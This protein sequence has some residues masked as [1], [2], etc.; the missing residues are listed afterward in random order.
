MPDRYDAIVVGVGGM[1]SAATYHLARRGCAVL[2]LE[3]FDVPHARGS[4]HG[5]TRMIRK[6][7][8]E[9]P[10]YVPL[11]DRAYDR[12]RDLEAEADE[13]LLFTEGSVAAGP[14]GS[15]DLAAARRTCLEHDLPFELLSSGEVADRYPAYDLP[16]DFRA[17][18][19][20]D[21]GFLAAE[22]CLLAHVR[23]AHAHGATIRAREPVMDWQ[24]TASG[25][26]VTTT[27]GT[28]AADRLVLT[29]GAW[30]G[31]LLE[32]LDPVT[33]VERQVL[34]WFQPR[35]PDR[36]AP[37]RFPVFTIDAEAGPLY[38]FP[39]FGVPGVKVGL[40]HHREEVVDPDADDWREPTP[41][42]ERLLRS[43]AER[44]VPAG[45]GPT[46]ALRTCLYTNSPDE[47]F[48]VDT[49]PAADEVVVAAG[50]SGHGYKFCSV[51]GE[52]LA[53]LV[54]TGTTAHPIGLFGLDRL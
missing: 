5:V 44:Y 36:F 28:Y 7:Y 38:G 35:D 21:G 17:L 14:A 30:T 37:E 6:A 10:G 20:P 9:D 29:A 11:L 32:G 51:V 42:D 16:D 1:G 18:Y 39:P 13:Q 31:D 3:Q 4:S 50:F 52:I 26:T 46:L 53:D 48:L 49:H 8:A 43:L 25:V 33:T 22:R 45:A 41:A 47:H 15:D 2:G 34:A 54:T 27:K 19:Q 23:Q 40:H 24:S 12:W